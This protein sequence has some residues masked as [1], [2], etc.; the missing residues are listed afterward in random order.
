MQFS[1]KKLTGGG[2]LPKLQVGTTATSL[3]D[4]IL[5]QHPNFDLE[6]INCAYIKSDAD[7][8]YYFDG[9]TPTTTDGFDIFGGGSAEQISGVPPAQIMLISTT[10]TANLIVAVGISHF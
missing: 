5:A 7:L 4:L 9:N 2:T 6:G 8:K 3:E 10:G 1:P